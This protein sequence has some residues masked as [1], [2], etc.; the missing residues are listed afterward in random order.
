MASADDLY[1]KQDSAWAQDLTNVYG[2]SS[3]SLNSLVLDSTN[4][5][6]VK[7]Y[8]C[9]SDDGGS[10]ITGRP[11]DTNKKAFLLK[12]QKVRYVSATDYIVK[13]TYLDTYTSDIWFRT[14]VMNSS[15]MTWR[16]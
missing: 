10:T 13:Q 1:V 16:D 14:G 6:V 5:P 8:I 4:D 9:R 15:G 3:L 11:D 2:N 7:Y 12:V